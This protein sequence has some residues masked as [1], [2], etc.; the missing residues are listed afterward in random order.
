MKQ[1]FSDIWKKSFELTPIGL[2]I[3]TLEAQFFEIIPPKPNPILNIEAKKPL[4]KHI[5]LLNQFSTKS[6]TFRIIEQKATN[7]CRE[8]GLYLRKGKGV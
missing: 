8:K 5:D 3:I 2:G 6:R 4:I 7:Y 1:P